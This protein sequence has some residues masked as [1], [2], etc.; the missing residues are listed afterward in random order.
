MMNISKFAKIISTEI[1]VNEQYISNI[2]NLLDEGSTV[3]FIAR[4]RKEKTNNLDETLIFEVS[5]HYDKLIELEKRKESILKS[6][7]SQ[8]LLDPE[9]EEK[10]KNTYD[11]VVLEDLYLPFKRST[12]TRAAVARENGL[13]PLAKFVIEQNKPNIDSIAKEFITE[14]IANVQEA[15]SGACDI[16]AEWF[17][18]DIKVRNIVR[19]EIEQFASLKTKISKNKDDEARKYQD[20]FEYEE[21][22]HKIP[23]HRFLAIMRA[24]NEKFIK[25]KLQFDEELIFNKSQKI[26]LKRNSTCKNLIDNTLKDSLDR[27]IFPSIENEIMSKFKQKADLEA[28]E[29]FGKN[30]KQLLLAPPLG[31]K[32]TLAIDPGF[33]TGCK[34]V[35]LAANGDL[36]DDAVIYPHPPHYKYYESEDIILS[37]CEK[38]EIEAIAIGNGTA[39][40]ETLEWVKNLDFRFNINIYLVNEDGASIYSA[41]K[42]AKDEFPEKDVTVR[43]A[44]SIGRRLMDP[45][46]ELVKISPKSI[47]VGQYQY[48]VDQKLLQ[49]KLDGIVLSAVNT[50]GV[51][52]NTASEHLLSY[53]SGLGPVLAKN[54]VKYRTKIGSF[55]NKAELEQ[56]PRLGAKAFQQSAGFLRIKNGENFLDNTGIHPE[57]HHIA[58]KILNDN[59]INQNEIQSKIDILKKTNLQS[60]ISEDIG[61][62]TLNDIIKELEKPGLDPRGIQEEIRFDQSVK[63]IEDLRLGMDITGI[64]VNI[65]NFGAFINLGIKEKG[66]LHISEMANKFIKDPN[67]IVKLNQQVKVK[68]KDIDIERSRIQLT[69]K[70]I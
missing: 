46:A 35:C 17:S 9:L 62:P 63:S 12:K 34:I 38:F 44:V 65:T 48:D 24:Q 22:L 57:S 8:G 32:R 27:L 68:V 61:L 36:L 11:S 20:Y 58:I 31:Q 67:T 3:P 54:I 26:V 49:E 15:I 41:S 19:E 53:I 14:K 1:N 6:I 59:N 43:G 55:I 16:V 21:K 60:Y 69:M 28:I 25:F 29:V 39:G 13:E 64:V 50:V 23:S 4:Y 18:E 52:L 66:L 30:L 5:E 33:R 70:G 47:G 51:N 37:L 42:T 56:V 40:L 45:L 7:E 2:I 10:I